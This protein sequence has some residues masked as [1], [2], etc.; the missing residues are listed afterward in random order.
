MTPEIAE[1]AFERFGRSGPISHYGGL[2][3]GL[4]LARSVIEAHGG[5]IRFVSQP[6]Q[7]STFVFDLPL[8]AT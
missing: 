2:G 5:A 6:N 1:R 3:L 7:G 4:Y 8:T